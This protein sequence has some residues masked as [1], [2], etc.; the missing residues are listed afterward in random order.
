[1]KMNQ[2]SSAIALL[3]TLLC[4]ACGDPL[5]EAQKL[6]NPR[7]LGVRVES[8]SGLATPDPGE[9]VSVQVLVAGTNGPEIA[10][11][12]Y[13]FC[14]AIDSARGVPICAGTPFGEG[15][16]EGAS[17][18]HADI[19]IPYDAEPGQRLA[20]LAAGCVD[21][22]PSLPEDPLDWSCSSAE[23]PLSVSFDAF[24]APDAE[25]ANR[26]P[27]L[28]MSE[29]EVDGTSVTYESPN[30]LP[31]C[32]DVPT[33]KSEETVK[34]HLRLSEEASEHVPGALREELQISHFANEGLYERQ[35][36]FLVPGEEVA[37]SLDW[38]APPS[39]G[40]VKHYVVVRDD[41]G[42]VSWRTFSVCVQ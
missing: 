3:A 35:Y 15:I 18:Q 33:V 16:L 17:E 37:V 34:V 8:A 4:A 30:D 9:Q 6:E 12:E 27:D 28:D 31:T 41:R 23:A 39:A 13:R 26:N 25:S 19:Q 40:P 20:L 10:T 29:I 7:V 42:G 11:F 38:E 36:S 2:P 14:P 5:K 21:G 1:M 32:N 24:L 22:T